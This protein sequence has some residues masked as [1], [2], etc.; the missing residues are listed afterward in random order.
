MPETSPHAGDTNRHPASV[1]TQTNLNARRLELLHRAALSFTAS[2]DLREVIHSVL[3]EAQATLAAG[4]WSVWLLDEA[5]TTLTCWQAQGPSGD[6]LQGYQI[7]LDRG[8]V[9]WAV[10]NNTRVYVQDLSSDPRRDDLISARAQMPAASL[11][12]CP[13]NIGSRHTGTVTTIGAIN[14]VSDRVNGFD[15]DDVALVDVL[16]ASAAT[17]I[18]NA[19]LYEQSQREV[20]RRKLV[21]G[22]LRQSEGQYRTLVETS[23][24]SIFLLSLDGK[25]LMCNHRTLALHGYERVTDV[26][27]RSF[28]SLVAPEIRAEAQDIFN[29]VFQ[30]HALRN[31]ELTLVRSDGTPFAGELG[32][33]LTAN[34]CG[35]PAGIVAFARDIS[36]RKEAEAA[37]RRHNLELRVLN[38]IAT[39]ISQSHDLKNLLE[40]ALDK[41][42][43]TL[44]I[45]TGWMVLFDPDRASLVSTEVE[46]RR[47]L[48]SKADIAE[49]SDSLL[50]R[51][52]ERASTT[53][54]P[55]ILRSVEL[56]ELYAGASAPCQV[57]AIPLVAQDQVVGA[58]AIAGLRHRHPRNISFRQVQLLA[59][60]GHQ[61]SVAVE[62]A[63]LTREA[64]EVDMLRQLDQMRADLMASFSHDLRSPLGLI[65][66][67]CSTLLRDDIDLDPTTQK[68][69]LSDIIAQTD[70]L[71]RLVDGILDLGKLGA[72]QLVLDSIPMDLGT[73]AQRLF[74]E[75]Q[76]QIPS[77][78]FTLDLPEDPL[79]VIADSVR[80]DQVLHNLLDNAVKYSPGGGPIDIR[81][82]RKRNKVLFS[83]SDSGLGI[84]EDQFD[85]I[86]ERFYRVKG[87]ATEHI[88]GTGLGLTTCRGIVEA[89]GGRIWATSALDVGSTFTFSLPAAPDVPEA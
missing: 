35:E 36:D 32:A 39:H 55:V 75:A 87:E 50:H 68:D 43:D 29:R 57:V 59:A 44:D 73:L 23:P 52:V 20:E 21:E 12:C 24:D 65:K 13:L 76:Q 63:R 26:L 82:Y 30:G 27:G 53:R 51:L 45:D 48:L 47:G 6:V 18:Y 72:G 31:Q 22:A 7:A 78:Q 46:I 74:D 79:I 2:L 17:A 10:R 80:I 8:V 5:D 83:I 38:D 37:V 70:R 85:L 54:Q 58:M 19:R 16:S 40:N 56:F 49:R 69:F 25:I 86:F 66:M 42:L 64:A 77:H 84:P 71:S 62:T 60:I 1:E 88:S 28:L 15:D 34:S 41:T 81:G 3:A 67:T 14:V 33:A 4:S 11:I 9:G 61:I 89:H